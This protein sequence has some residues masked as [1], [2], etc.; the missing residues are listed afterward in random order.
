MKHTV[1]ALIARPRCLHG[2]TLTAALCLVLVVAIPATANPI[3]YTYTGNDFGTGDVDGV[4]YTTNDFISVSITLAAPLAP[5]T[6][7]IIVGAGGC[8]GGGAEVFPASGAPGFVPPPCAGFQ[9]TITD[10]VLTLS[11]NG[12]WVSDLELVTN[13]EG[14]IDNWVIAVDKLTEPNQAD[15]LTISA[16]FVGDTDG[17]QDYTA[18]ENGYGYIIGNPGS[19]SEEAPTV[20]EP[21]TL[22]LLFVGLAAGALKRKGAKLFER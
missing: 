9:L 19:W 12:D 22:T 21:G 6:D 10:G 20:P 17:G 2:I 18:S 5:D 4:V 1:T 15:L 11:P 14:E 16:G 3:T 8:G 13:S 7:A